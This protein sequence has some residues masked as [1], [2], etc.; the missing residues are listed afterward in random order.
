[1]YAR[2]IIKAIALQVSIYGPFRAMLT[3]IEKQS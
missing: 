2:F 3:A 1:M